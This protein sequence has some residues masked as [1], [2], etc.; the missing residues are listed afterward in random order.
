MH[1][2][3]YARMS[4]GRRRVA[5]LYC[6]DGVRGDLFRT[7]GH[8]TAMTRAMVRRS[9]DGTGPGHLGRWS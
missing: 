3:L 1:I 9:P 6:E 7:C 4:T 2:A 5:L 8:W